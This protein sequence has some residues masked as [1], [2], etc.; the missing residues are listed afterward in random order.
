MKIN[1]DGVKHMRQHGFLGRLKPFTQEERPRVVI[2]DHMDLSSVPTPPAVVDYASKVASW[3]MYYN[4]QLGD[5]TCAGYGHALQAWTA[6]AGQEITLPGAP[7]LKMYE[8][9]GGYVPGDPDTDNGCVMQSVLEYVE[10]E[11]VSGH[12]ILAFAELKN[13]SALKTVLNLFGTVYIGVN[14]PESALTQFDNEQPWTVVR[15][16]PVAGGHCVVIQKYDTQTD[17]IEV[18]TWGATQRVSAQWAEDYIEEAWVIITKDWF[19]ANGD[20]VTGLDLA[21]LGAD[22]AS[23]TGRKNPFL[24][25]VTETADSLDD[26]EESLERGLTVLGD[27]PLGEAWESLRSHLRSALDRLRS[28]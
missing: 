5:C 11:G 18:V 2:D 6:Y 16:S 7:I 23:I 22:Y 28:L 10:K 12:E 13:I 1:K 21:A 27:G 25:T 17:P 14:L 20:T 26:L 9:V 15:D 4:D 24:D 8:V 3:P 19:E